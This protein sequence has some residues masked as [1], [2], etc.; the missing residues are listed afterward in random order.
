MAIRRIHNFNEL[1][2][3]KTTK[4]KTLQNI[5]DGTFSHLVTYYGPEGT[6]KSSL[7]KLAI[8][9]LLCES[10]NGDVPC[11]VC[12]KCKEIDKELID[13]NRSTRNVKIY[14]MSDKGGVDK[15]R[16]IL[17]EV[18]NNPLGEN[19]KKIIYLE[20]IQ[21]MSE[22]AQ[23]VL[24]NDFEIFPS[25]VYVICSTTGLDNL[26]K[27]FVSRMAK[28][29]IKPLEPK[30]MIELLRES[31][32]ERGLSIEHEDTVVELLATW[33]DYKPRNALSVLEVLGKNCS[34]SVEEI[35][36]L[37]ETVD[38][39]E[40]L[41][42]IASF[43]GQIYTGIKA[44]EKLNFNEDVY[45]SFVLLVREA[46]YIKINGTSTRLSMEETMQIKSAVE[47]LDVEVILK[48]L[49]EV[50]H[51]IRF[52]STALLG[53]Y[54]DCHPYMEKVYRPQLNALN[55]EL[56]EK[57][58]HGIFMEDETIIDP[59]ADLNDDRVITMEEVLE[60][61]TIVGNGEDLKGFRDLFQ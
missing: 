28:Y 34:V 15:A 35:R 2:G 1:K 20:E 39:N 31:I 55:E 10:E 29:P 45:K 53:C 57:R 61:S 3:Q 26:T 23:G 32:E 11:G 21:G 40:F 48:F 25:N 37:I 30:L 5:A 22:Q 51:M 36:D 59:D 14:N 52:N 17:A 47:N 18:Q 33:A 12:N 44:I 49:R 13:N 58:E 27:P 56:M 41:P 19:E 16:E 8:K 60:N 46:F 6:G 50:T 42:I 7:A 4:S 43:N 54:M 24:L 9:A 38:I